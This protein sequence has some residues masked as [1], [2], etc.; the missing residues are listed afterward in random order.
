M[1]FVRVCRCAPQQDPNNELYGLVWSLSLQKGS[2]KA[3]APINEKAEQLL[4]L[5]VFSNSSLSGQVLS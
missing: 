5:S 3:G 4:H 2:S 1:T